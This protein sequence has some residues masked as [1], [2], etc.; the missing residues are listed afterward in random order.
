MTRR[1]IREN[2]GQYYA[3]RWVARVRG[4]VVAQG[5]TRE[6]AYDAARVSRPK[7][8]IEIILMSPIFDHPLVKAVQDVLPP[9]QPLYIV[10]GALR[11]SLLGRV[12]HDL[13]FAVP[14]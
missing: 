6:A 1:R 2:E 12:T 13:D 11:D 7:D 10:G 3:G 9:G 4:K 5:A 14:A 8:K